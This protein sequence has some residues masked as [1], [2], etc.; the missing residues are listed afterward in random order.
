M[1]RNEA[2]QLIENH[3]RECH[4]GLVKKL[5]GPAGSRHHAEDVVQE[6]YTRACQ[7]WPSFSL[8]SGNLEQWMS[9]ILKNCMAAHKREMM[10]EGEVV[11]V[12]VDEVVYHY[13]STSGMVKEIAAVIDEKESGEK[14]IL[15]LFFFEGYQ[16]ADIEKLVPQTNGAIRQVLHRFK[17]E[18]K[19]KYK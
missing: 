13:N 19:E 16:P 12:D 8:S 17:Q 5:S 1:N 9:A 14:Y 7:Y 11:D 2:Y 15:K 3:Y 10:R 18:M 4:E 6:M